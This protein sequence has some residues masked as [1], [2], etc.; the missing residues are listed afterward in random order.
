M[1]TSLGNTD[2]QGAGGTPYVPP[3][4]GVVN[5][6]TTCGGCVFSSGSSL[7]VTVSQAYCGPGLL[8]STNTVTLP[9]DSADV[10]RVRYELDANNWA[11]YVCASNMW[12]YGLEDWGSAGSTGTCIGTTGPIERIQV[13][14]CTGFE[15]REKI[16]GEWYTVID[17]VRKNNT[18]VPIAY[19]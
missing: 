4:G 6:C 10:T 17:A 9:F 2:S 11:E 19:I 15:V 12:M 13:D 18:C 3:A 16:N 7:E 8:F 1:P 14:K 5:P